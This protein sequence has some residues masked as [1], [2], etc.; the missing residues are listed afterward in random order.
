VKPPRAPARGIL[1]RMAKLAIAKSPPSLAH[2]RWARF[3]GLS[4]PF[5]LVQSTRVLPAL[6]PIS[7]IFDGAG[8]SDEGE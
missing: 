2:R 8:H 4:S 3:G 6:P 5:S 7:G 1:I